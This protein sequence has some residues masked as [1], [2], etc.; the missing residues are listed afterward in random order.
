MYESLHGNNAGEAAS[1]VVIQ[2][3]LFWFK[4]LH[5]CMCHWRFPTGFKDFASMIQP[6]PI[7]CPNVF[8]TQG[9][10]FEEFPL[11]FYQFLWDRPKVRCKFVG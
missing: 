3:Y 5:F 1:V 7:K 2:C 11:T 9:P 6:L 8:Q 10:Y 4:D